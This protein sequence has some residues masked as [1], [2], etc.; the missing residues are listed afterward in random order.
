MTFKCSFQAKPHYDSMK[1]SQLLYVTGSHALPSDI[2]LLTRTFFNFLHAFLSIF[3]FFFFNF[4]FTQ[5]AF[6]HEK[7]E[8]SRW[9]QLGFLT[10]I[11]KYFFNSIG[12]VKPMKNCWLICQGPACTPPMTPGPTWLPLLWSRLS[13]WLLTKLWSSPSLWSCQEVVGSGLAR[14]IVPSM[15]LLPHLV[16]RDRAL[17]REGMALLAP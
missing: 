4:F 1:I 10:V 8:K 5:M 9:W 2:L 14:V 3:L 7:R 12:H 6:S 13:D 11:L 17:L 15:T 16:L